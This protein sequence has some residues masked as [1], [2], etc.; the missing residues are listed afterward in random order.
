MTL[1]HCA[2]EP[3]RVYNVFH[4]SLRPSKH[5]NRSVVTL[6]AVNQ[7]RDKLMPSTAAHLPLVREWDLAYHDSFFQDLGYN[8]LSA[9][10]HVGVNGLHHAV[11]SHIGFMQYACFAMAKPSLQLNAYPT[12]IAYSSPGLHRYDCD[13]ELPETAAL[14]PNIA[15]YWFPAA[16]E[17]VGT[18]FPRA[19]VERHYASHFGRPLR[20]SDAI[21]RLDGQFISGNSFLIPRWAYERLFPW[22]LQVAYDL[23]PWVKRSNDIPR[24]HRH[25]GGI[26]ERVVGLSIAAE[27]GLE[28]QR[29]AGTMELSFRAHNYKDSRD[30]GDESPTASRTMRRYERRSGDARLPVIVPGHAAGSACG[31]DASEA[32]AKNAKLEST[33]AGSMPG[34]MLTPADLAL[35]TASEALI[36]AKREKAKE[37]LAEAEAAEH[38]MKREL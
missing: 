37:L 30:F 10:V 25:V 32:A 36:A 24:H 9:L 28:L 16:E 17:A 4:Y 20:I 12:R 19:W 38:A 7:R 5:L 23:F 2:V 15:F 6:Y 1:G 35:Q 21:E 27:D 26:M 11:G 34:A 33:R 31:V 3:M 29:L 8:E 18:A 14:A 22:W 13:V